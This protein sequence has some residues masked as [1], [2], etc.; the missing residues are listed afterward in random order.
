MLAWLGAVIMALTVL[1]AGP[2]L[3]AKDQA[4]ENELDPALVHDFTVDPITA[5][6][7][8]GDRSAGSPGQ[9]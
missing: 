4:H 1:S 3:A 8:L 6:A 2:G 9:L 5:L 7:S